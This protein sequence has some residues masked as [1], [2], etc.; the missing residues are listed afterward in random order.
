MADR[1]LR[2]RAGEPRAVRPL[3][4]PGR[5]GRRR[6]RRPRAPRQHEPLSA[7]A[8]S[9]RTRR[10][11]EITDDYRRF[12]GL[13]SH[14]YFHSWNVKRIKPA[15]F[16]P[17]DLARE[18]YTRQLW[19][20]EGITSYYDDLALVRSG[21]IEPRELSGARR[22]RPSP[23][24]CAV[25]GGTSRA[26][27][28]RASMP[29][30]STT[31]AT[32]TR[33]TPSSATTPRA[34]WSRSRSTSRCADAASSLDA[35][36]RALWQ[37]HGETGVGVPEDG[38][39]SIAIELAGDGP[40]RL[41]RA[42]RS[43]G[44]TTRRWR[45]CSRAFGMTLHLRPAEGESRP[46]R[47]GR[48]PGGCRR[49][50]AQLAWAR[51]STGGAQATLQHVFSGGPAERAGLAGRRRRRRH[52]RPA[53]VRRCDRKAAPP[54]ARRRNA[55]GARVPARRV[56]HDSADAR[57][58]AERHLLACRSTRTSTTPRARAARPGSAATR[59]AAS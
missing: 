2:R 53:H 51:A 56:D 37:R 26:S 43:T 58:G 11:R 47:Q 16:V 4:V 17:Y 39:E 18:N 59:S 27:P 15:A 1:S 57:R 46:R 5:R 35:L 54:P 21:V 7:S 31:G 45:I 3:S 29:G 24:C 10:S 32:R 8:T 19:A 23:T 28:S 48:Q 34:R 9:C 50:A 40:D 33:R 49:A 6:L 20:F 41:L 12:L 30:S 55:R 13:A 22:D 42:L 52:R 14:E 36:M 25:P 44:P 38:I